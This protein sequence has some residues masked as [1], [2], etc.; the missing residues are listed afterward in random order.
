[1]SRKF[2]VGDLVVATD[3]TETVTGRITKTGPHIVKVEGS[4]F[5]KSSVI[6]REYKDQFSPW[7]ESSLRD[8]DGELTCKIK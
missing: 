2:K 4:I 7:N 3:E 6:H 1:M 8:N 5:H